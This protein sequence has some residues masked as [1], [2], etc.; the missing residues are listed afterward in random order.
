MLLVLLKADLLAQII[1]DA[2]D[3][4]AHIAGFLRVL[5]NLD[6]LPLLPADHRGEEL[7]TR[8]LRQ[9]HDTVHDLVNGLLPDLLAAFGAMRHA[10]ARP[11]KAHIV[12]DLRHRAD[13]GTGVFGGGLLVN[14]D[15]GRQALDIVH[16]RLVHL[17]EEHP[18]IGAQALHIAALAFGI[19]GVEG[20]ARFPAAGEARDD[21][22]LVPGDLHVDI[23]QI[24]FTGAFDKNAVLQ[25]T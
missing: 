10:D 17:S 18:G 8:P 21:H 15:G 22:E 13:G 3:A 20:E 24:V 1:D 19:D 4:R 5:Q 16:V 2:V 7:Q 25:H 23:L 6:M 9:G 14:G 12:M 11:E